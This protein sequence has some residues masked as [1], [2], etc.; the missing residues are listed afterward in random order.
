MYLTVDDG[1]RIY[2]EDHGDPRAFPLILL[3]GWGV[4][5]ALWSEQIPFLVEHGYRVITMDARGHGKSDNGIYSK[6]MNLLEVVYDDLQ[7]LLAHLDINST[8]GIIGHSAGGGIGMSVYLSNPEDVEFL[9]ILNSSY[10]LYE[11]IDERIIWSLVPDLINIGFNPILRGPYRYLVKKSIPIISIMLN[12]PRKKVEMWVDDIL[13]VRK[14]V[15][16]EE[17]KHLKKYNLKDKLNKIYVPCLIIAGEY[18]WLTPPTRS[19]VLHKYIPNSEFHIIK[20]TGHLSKVERSEEVN[21]LI[22]NFIK[23]VKNNKL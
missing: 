22:L 13:S 20:N 1:V 16:I 5:S 17:L 15:L 8:Y 23:R 6:D 10:T 3:H 7:V 11:R 18:D 12:K 21:E 4:S 14:K 9:C 2:Y 19:K